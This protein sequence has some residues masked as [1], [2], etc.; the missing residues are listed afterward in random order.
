M[1]SALRKFTR[2]NVENL[3]ELRRKVANAAIESEKYLG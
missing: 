2:Y 1:L 3:L